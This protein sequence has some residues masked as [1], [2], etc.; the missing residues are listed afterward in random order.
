[1]IQY[2]M[3]YCDELYYEDCKIGQETY[4]KETVW[5]KGNKPRYVSNYDFESFTGFMTMVTTQK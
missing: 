1:V 5:S 4:T 2:M 3:K